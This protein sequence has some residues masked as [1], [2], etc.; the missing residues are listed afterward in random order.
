MAAA[1][2][3][4]SG[5]GSA[6]LRH[7]LD[8]WGRRRCCQVRFIRPAHVAFEDTRNARAYTSQPHIPHLRPKV[9]SVGLGEEA[10]RS[11][12][13]SFAGTAATD[14]AAKLCAARLCE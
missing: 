10:G 8:P 3:P 2:Q 5:R 11:G 1:I 6:A 13:Y 12:R 4:G 7:K 14:A 9:R